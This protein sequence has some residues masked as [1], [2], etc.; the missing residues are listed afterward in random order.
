MEQLRISRATLAATVM[1]R[2]FRAC[3]HDMR[4]ITSGTRTQ[5]DRRNSVSEFRS[6]VS[7]GPNFQEFLRRSP[8]SETAAVFADDGKEEFDKSDLYQDLYSGSDRKGSPSWLC[9]L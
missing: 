5:R 9:P 6:R 1:L 8:V 3:K 4:R 7:S 2:G